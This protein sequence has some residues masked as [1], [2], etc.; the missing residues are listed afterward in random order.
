MKRRQGTRKPPRSE[1]LP[2]MRGRVKAL[3][4]MSSTTA[5]F[6][7]QSAA[8][9]KPGNDA[10]PQAFEIEFPLL[11]SCAIAALGATVATIGAYRLRKRDRNGRPKAEGTES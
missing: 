7:L 10:S 4:A 3:A 8:L 9:A 2:A 5:I 6:A 11:G 1:A